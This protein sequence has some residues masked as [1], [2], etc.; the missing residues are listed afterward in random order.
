MRPRSDSSSSED[1][2]PVLNFLPLRENIDA[3]SKATMKWRL[4]IGSAEKEKILAK[5]SALMVELE[6]FKKDMLWALQYAKEDLEEAEGIL[7]HTKEPWVLPKPKQ[8]NLKSTPNVI[9]AP[10]P[11]VTGEFFSKPSSN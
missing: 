4:A 11:K 2:E 3:I 8:L 5:V 7:L 10:I 6:N 9:V 1:S